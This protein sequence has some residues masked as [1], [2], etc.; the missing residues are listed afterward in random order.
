MT[1]PVHQNTAKIE[2]DCP[3]EIA[4]VE[5]GHLIMRRPKVR[6]ML[7]AQHSS[8]NQADQAVTLVA[9]LCE[10]TVEDVHELDSADWD[11]LERQVAVFKRAKS[12]NG[13]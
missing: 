8:D 5:V 6:D 12:Q 4:G 9:N 7:A 1:K 2:L 10:I 13:S 3:V 11:K